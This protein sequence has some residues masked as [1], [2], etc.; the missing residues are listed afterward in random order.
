[1]K[2][3]H[4]RKLAIIGSGPVGTFFS[5]I[6][7]RIGFEVEVYEKKKDPTVPENREDSRFINFTL[8]T[9]ALA[10]LEK[11]GLKERLQKLGTMLYGKAI[12]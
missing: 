8:G 1:M 2:D 11:I 3:E 5:I 6:L 12:H 4:Q 7:K 9:R 10:V